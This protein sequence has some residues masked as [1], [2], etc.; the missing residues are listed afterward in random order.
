LPLFIISDT[1]TP[2]GRAELSGPKNHSKVTSDSSG[3]GSE[4]MLAEHVR[5]ISSS[6]LPIMVAAGEIVTAPMLTAW[7]W[8]NR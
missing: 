3:G 1:I 5:V 2:E 7:P 6:V 8:Y 4:V